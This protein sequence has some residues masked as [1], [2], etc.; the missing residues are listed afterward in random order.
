TNLVYKHS[1]KITQTVFSLPS[2][3]KELYFF[4]HNK[5]ST[6]TIEV[7]FFHITNL[8]STPYR[9]AKLRRNRIGKKTFRCFFYSFEVWFIQNSWIWRLIIRL[10]LMAT[11]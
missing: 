11:K 4:K 6:R 2:S 10:F 3:L 8:F 7:S 1:Y 5:P 9:I